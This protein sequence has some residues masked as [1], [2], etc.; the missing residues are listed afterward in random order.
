MPQQNPFTCSGSYE[1]VGPYNQTLFLGC[2]LTSFNINLGW[3]A[4]ASSITIGLVS[5]PAYHPVSQ[6]YGPLNALVASTNANTNNTSTALRQNADGS[7]SDTDPGR[8]LFKTISPAIADQNQYNDLGKVY[9]DTINNRKKYWTDPD[10]GFLGLAKYQPDGQLVRKAYDIIGVPAFF[11]FS[12]GLSFGGMISDWKANGG[13]GGSG[14]FEVTLKSYSSLLAGS[15]LIIDE[16]VGSISTEINSTIAVPSNTTGVYTSDI[17]KGNMPNIFNVFGYLE[18]KGFGY[19]GKT[20]S[21]VSALQIYYALQDLTGGKDCP[22]SPYGALIAKHPLT[23]DGTAVDVTNQTVTSLLSSN[24]TMTL[25]ECGLCPN[26]TA[27]DDIKRTKLK[28]DLSEVPIPPN[29]LFLNGMSYIT[30]LDFIT[31][32]CHGAGFEFYVDFRLP[33]PSIPDEVGNFSG[34]IVIRTVSRRNQPPR[35]IIKNIVGNLV[36]AG[37]KISSYTYGQEYNDKE[38]RAMYIGSKQQRLLQVRSV[39]L[40]I[41]QSSL[42]F[43]PY[44]DNGR[45]HFVTFNS[46]SNSNGAVPNINRYENY[47]RIP[48]PGSTRYSQTATDGGSAVGQI[49]DWDIFQ[50]I[51]NFGPNSLGILRGNYFPTE[52]QDPD[53]LYQGNPNPAFANDESYPIY[54]DLIS[55]YF[56]YHGQDTTATTVPSAIDWHEPRKVYLDRKMGQL[57]IVFRNNDITSLLTKAFTSSG[58]FVVLENEIR[59]AGGGFEAWFS[60]CFDN[61]FNTDI[62][63]LMYSAFCA[64]YPVFGSRRNFLA[65]LN[66]INWDAVNKS[67]TTQTKETRAYTVSI[68]NAQPYVQSL[69]ADL[70]KIHSF[71]SDICNTYYAKK[72]M[73]KTPRMRWYQ[74]SPFSN[75]DGET[76][77]RYPDPNGNNFAYSTSS[78]FFT[79]WEI[80]SD[81]AWE[82]EGNFIDDTIVIGSTQAALFSDDNNKILPILGF[83]ANGDFASRDFW[84]Q[85]YLANR[86]NP[87][88]LTALMLSRSQPF[89]S[90][91]DRGIYFYFP[92]DHNMDASDYTYIPYRNPTLTNLGL[93]NLTNTLVGQTLAPTT[94]HGEPIPA[95][96]QY[97]MYAKAQVEPKVIFL[98]DVDDVYRPRAILSLQSPLYLGGGKSDTQDSLSYVQLHDVLIKLNRGS[99]QPPNNISR[100]NNS[101]KATAN[102]MNWKAILCAWGFSS[103]MK[104]IGGYHGIS[105]NNSAENVTIVKKAVC[106]EFAAIPIKFNRATYG[107]WINHPGLQGISS[108]IFIPTDPNNGYDQNTLNNLVNNLVGG[109][110]LNID[111]NLNP[112]NYGGTNALDAVVM[113]QIKDDVNYQQVTEHGNINAVGML[114]NDPN[115][116]PYSIGSVLKLTAADTVGPIVTNLGLSLNNGGITSNYNMRTYVKKIGFFNKEN[117]DKIKDTSLEFMK[118]RRD[119]NTSINSSLNKIKPNTFPNTSNGLLGGADTPKPLRW[120]PFEVLAGAAY[121]QLNFKSSVGDIYTDLGFS[122][123]WSKSPYSKTASYNTK[124]ML[125]YLTNVSVQDIQEL[126]REFKDDYSQKSFMS[127]DGLLSP[128]S[129]YP[130]LYGSTYNITKYSRDHC[131]FCKGNGNYT[132]EKFDIPRDTGIQPSGFAG[133]IQLKVSKTDIC[134]FCEP[135]SDKAKRSYKSTSPKQTNPPYI[136]ASGDDLTII[137][138]NA[139]TGQ[140]S[141][142]NNQNTIINYST[143]N[144]ILLTSGEFSCFQNRQSGDLTGHSIDLIAFGMTVPET[145]NSLKLAYSSTVE[146]NFLDYDQNYID[147]CKEKSIPGPTG[148][149][150][151]PA[152]NA[153]F[154]GLRG[155]LMV[156]AWGYDLEGFP[157]PNSSGEPKL[158][159][160]GNIVRDSNGNTIY[161][162][163]IQKSDQTWTEPYKETSFY[164]GWGQLPGTWP[165]GP[166]DLRW[167]DIAGVWVAGGNGYKPIWIV[168]ETDLVGNQPSRGEIVD[169]SYSNQP[170]AS[171]LRRL[172]FVKDPL[173]VNGAPR[174]AHIYCNYNSQ[175]GFYEPIYNKVS[176]SSGIIR[177]ANSVDMY[178]M[179]RNTTATYLTTFSNPLDFNV[180][181]GDAGLF[182]FIGS[183]WVLQS[184][185]C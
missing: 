145:G 115:G 154:F 100:T 1:E 75:S 96:W 157:V 76:Y 3:G 70:K 181:V 120:S 80:S 48:D 116:K 45:G 156:H 89:G 184:Y 67:T 14:L 180:N 15:Y 142:E 129:F 112:W 9:W 127:L 108:L 162:N 173:G 111:D 126:P 6:K 31:K 25:Q 158:D 61:I 81:G 160:N 37:A 179:Y 150:G 63:D 131:A 95:D 165:V 125:R 149:S 117:S 99:A 49:N 163:Q 19:A 174:G 11:K 29:D 147:H 79:N 166:V 91:V 136:L 113:N 168:I 40:S 182:T 153:R 50:S 68:E 52:E 22:F 30:I 16:Y 130:T 35:E 98:K 34:V 107:P 167:D 83:N 44:Y 66:I 137:S 134:P 33:D 4:D 139:N 110:K 87:N 101:L 148:S 51:V 13:Q 46:T 177:G 43:D 85:T 39:N 57:Q 60:Y 7:I 5:D 128:I 88:S 178:N 159:Y 94:A 41:K 164:K 26:I 146:K 122:P 23:M 20:E 102:P 183:G 141:G 84:S 69:Y 104:L 151:C 38:V 56:G 118:R 32:I 123:S 103:T 10:P 97:K 185:R 172:V 170:L 55:P 93:T 169:D 135:A 82:E 47:F 58:E 17:V 73:V 18:N 21:G 12:S 161:K 74:T 90:A 114:L 121:P 132:W 155:P 138:K 144:P 106:P 86:N 59:A 36:N 42:V 143:L 77:V 140:P 176:L 72:F 54:N 28:L 65:G 109:V 133:L 64:Q 92:L 124:D 71:F 78:R 8:N 24:N 105:I 62:A 2:S 119:T 175:N 27:K 171:G 152:N 53:S